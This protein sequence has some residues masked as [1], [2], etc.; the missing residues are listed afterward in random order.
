ML[1]QNDFEKNFAKYLEDGLIIK[2]K[3]DLA[4]GMYLKNADLSLS[5]AIDCLSS[6][7]KPFLWVVVISYYAMFYSANAVLLH[8]GYKVGDKIAHRVTTQV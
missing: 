7:L 2:T 1:N 6:S 3:N 5:L 8:H 4:K